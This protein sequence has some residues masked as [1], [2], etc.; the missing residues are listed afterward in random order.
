MNHSLKFSITEM[1]NENKFLMAHL[2]V[3]LGF[4]SS[5]SQA[6]KNGWDK[7]LELGQH[8]L[9]SKKKRINVEILP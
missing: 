7:P 4:F 8:E 9:G 6:K 5:V 3:D 1:Q 2:M